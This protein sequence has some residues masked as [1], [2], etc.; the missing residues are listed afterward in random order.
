MQIRELITF[1]VNNFEQVLEVTF[2]TD[3]DSE[4]VCRDSKISFS[5]LS[6]FGYDFHEKNNFDVFDEFDIYN[7]DDILS[8][9]E[10]EII[11]F[12]EEYYSSYPNKLPKPEL[13]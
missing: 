8:L 9:N 11:S 5:L 13:Y 2:R 6:D 10:E 3:M 1:Y 4:E 12:L 7:E